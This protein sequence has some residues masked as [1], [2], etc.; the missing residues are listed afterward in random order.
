MQSIENFRACETEI[1]LS[2][3]EHVFCRTYAVGR[4][5]VKEKIES[6]KR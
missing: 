4:T 5:Q 1:Q 6:S 2:E 3:V